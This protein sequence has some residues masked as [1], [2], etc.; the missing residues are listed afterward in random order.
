[1]YNHSANPKCIVVDS[2][3]S[4]PL[5]ITRIYEL[6]VDLFVHIVGDYDYDVFVI[7]K[8]PSPHALIPAYNT[9][10]LGNR[11]QLIGLVVM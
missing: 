1:M 4:S 5:L 7:T 2:S 11:I 9:P 10:L 8:H 6:G 3:F